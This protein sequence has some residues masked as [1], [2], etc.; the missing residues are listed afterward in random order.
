M[1]NMRIV[2]VLAA[3]AAMFIFGRA[4]EVHAAG[5][6]MAGVK[7][8]RPVPHAVESLNDVQ[9]RALRSQRMP[10]GDRVI[11]LRRIRKTGDTPVF[12]PRLY[13]EL[14]PAVSSL[15]APASMAPAL[16]F[17]F[18]GLSNPTTFDVVPPDTMGAAGPNHLV[19]F[20]NTQVAFFNKSGSLASSI[21]SLISFWDSFGLASTI[22]FDPR[23]LFDLHSGRFIT[24]AAG[25]GP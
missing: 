10:E 25:L 18:A 19:S 1:K 15:F 11:P 17:N 4:H 16:D 13:L 7:V 23:V 9:A 6:P 21:V 8:T 12:T 22:A 2:P 20:L 5:E 3:I 14:A 24:S